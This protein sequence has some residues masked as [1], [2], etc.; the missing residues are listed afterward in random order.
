MGSQFPL[1][2]PND[3]TRLL[4]IHPTLVHWVLGDDFHR[5]IQFP[6]EERQDSRHCHHP[7]W[8]W[9]NYELTASASWYFSDMGHLSS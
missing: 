4:L 1:N 5:E 9:Q 6:D 8:W 2:F 3:V 7:F